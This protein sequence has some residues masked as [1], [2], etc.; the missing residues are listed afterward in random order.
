MSTVSVEIKGKED[1]STAA[2]KAASSL[3]DVTSGAAGMAASFAPVAIAGAAVIAAIRQVAQT[4]D[5]CVTEFA[6][7]ERAA[8]AFNAAIAQS[9]TISVAAGNAL[10]KFA[11]EIATMTGET[12]ESVQSMETLLVTSGRTEGE[13]RKLISAAVDMSAATGKDLRTSVEELNKTFSGTE[14]RMSQLI[15]EL[16]D[17]T[18]EELKNGGAID[19]VA[20][21]Y[22][23]LGEALQDSTDVSI[24][25]YQNA[26]DDLKSSLGGLIS[27]G[28]SPLRDWLT[29]LV[30]QWGEAASAARNYA[31]AQA[32]IKGGKGVDTLSEVELEALNKKKLAYI[33]ELKDL[34]A[35]SREGGDMYKLQTQEI[36]RAIAEQAAIAEALRN[37]SLDRAFQQYKPGVAPAIPAATSP[38]GGSVGGASSGTTGSGRI[39]D[40][41]KEWNDFVEAHRVGVR[42]INSGIDDVIAQYDN[43]D[44]RM[45]EG[46]SIWKDSIDA[47]AAQYREWNLVLENITLTLYSGVTAALETVGAA[48]FNQK[49][50]WNDLG[51]IALDVLAQVLRGIGAQLAGLAAVH[52]ISLDFV[53]GGLAAAGAA[54]AFVAAGAVDAWST[55]LTGAPADA[56]A[57]GSAVGVPSGTSGTGTTGANASYSQARDV[58]VNVSVTTST[59][60]GDDGIRQFS[61][62]IWREIQ[63][64]GV[65]GAA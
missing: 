5:E 46:P 29:D 61:L 6:A 48:I 24:K 50:V 42:E 59:L 58:T 36:E 40:P 3:G 43:L 27:L 16:K 51:K 10:A 26:M 64:A 1:V 13:V 33:A 8:I 22:A 12:G 38:G 62:M 31:T 2:K 52:F 9:G 37:F 41:E 15:P 28:L 60:V 53:G 7:N 14:G 57:T 39:N 32:K 19:I 23:G 30:R 35:G 47:V 45:V 11:E 63:S 55:S 34:R 21:K 4:V 65:L 54:A 25:N 20:A 17:L 18:D 56:Y 49:F 44:N